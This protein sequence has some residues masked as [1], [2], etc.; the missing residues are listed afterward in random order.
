MTKRL[1]VLMLGLLT[2]GCALLAQTADEKTPRELEGVGVTEHLGNTVDLGLE[3]TAEDG[4]Q[5]KLG[6]YFGKGKPVIVNLVYF[7]CPMLC[8]LVLN[9]QADMMRQ[10]AWTA[11]KE[12]EVV[13][14]SIDPAENFEMARKK[15]ASY[16]ASYERQTDGWHFLADHNGNVKKLASQLGFG[17]RWDAQISQYAHPAVIFVLSPKG[18]ISR[19]LYGVKFKPLDARLALSEASEGK[20]GL[21][22]RFLLY[23]FHYDPV[24]RSYVPFAR[25]FMRGGGVLMV[26]ILGLVLL[27]L[28]RRERKLAHANRQMVTAK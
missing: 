16:L 2:A 12:Y 22:E 26:L 7:Q 27:R 9:G 14:I 21:S 5:H 23:C 24:S 8:N 25:N 4:Y 20:T 1:A 18:L 11:G 15:K 13:T 19:Y 28:W 6:E 10:L 3:F 17:Y